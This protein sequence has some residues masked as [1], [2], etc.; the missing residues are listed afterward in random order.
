MKHN[1]RNAL[2]GVTV[3]SVLVL[4]AVLSYKLVSSRES[5]LGL[6]PQP[7]LSQTEPQV[8]DKNS[9]ITGRS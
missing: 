5:N 9:A 7:D 1:L 8:A 6:L 4:V 3:T 2:I